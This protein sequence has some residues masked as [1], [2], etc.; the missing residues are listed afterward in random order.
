MAFYDD[1]I[2]GVRRLARDKFRNPS[3]MAD[4]LGLSQSQISKLLNGR[5]MPRLDFVGELVD[6]LGGKISFPN[7]AES[8]NKEDLDG[9]AVLNLMGGVDAEDYLAVPLTSLGVAAKPEM[10]REDDIE[11]WVMV[12]RHHD[13]IRFKEHFVAIRVEAEDRS[14]LPMFGPNDMLLVDKTDNAPDPSGRLMLVRE[15]GTYGK[16]YVR[17][18]ATRRKGNDTE[19]VFYTENS[20]DYPP[21]V[22]SL[23]EHYGNNIQSALAGAIVWAWTDVRNK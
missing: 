8:T 19:L 18:V 9:D 12:W 21:Q 13:A 3:R 22:Y 20:K 16:A 15:P 6:K 14:V 2:D 17:R 11:S 4:Q 23:R 10:I 7:N 1:L 5:S